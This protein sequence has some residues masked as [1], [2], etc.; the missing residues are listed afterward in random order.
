MNILM[1]VEQEGGKTPSCLCSN[2]T[3]GYETEDFNKADFFIYTY[4]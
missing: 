3:T 2:V 1:G 4:K